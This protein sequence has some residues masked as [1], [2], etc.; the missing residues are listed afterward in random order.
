MGFILETCAPPLIRRH[1]G[2]PIFEISR[3]YQ[4]RRLPVAFSGI[5]FLTS[6]TQKMVAKAKRVFFENWRNLAPLIFVRKSF[7]GEVLDHI[8]L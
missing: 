2:R 4:Q 8:W 5:Q 7:D 3:S 1:G 6:G